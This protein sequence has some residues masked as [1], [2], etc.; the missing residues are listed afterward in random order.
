M[1]AI[2]LGA[3]LPWSREP[4]SGILADG[5][6]AMACAVAGLLIYALTVNG[7]VSSRWWRISSVP[8]ALACIVLSVRALNGYG[9]L[10][11]IVTAVAALAWLVVAQRPQS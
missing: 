9:A 10:G 1:F 6:Y 11:A 5:K 2:C 7:R 8:L 3:V 4:R